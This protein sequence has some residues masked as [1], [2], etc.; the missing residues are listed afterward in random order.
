MLKKIEVSDELFIAFRD[1]VSA[2]TGLFFQN[3]KRQDLLRGVQHAA[4]TFGYK[5]AKTCMTQLLKVN[6][7]EKQIQTLASHLTV[8]ETHFY[9]H[10]EHLNY[11]VEKILGSGNFTKNMSL[12]IWSAGCCTGEE[13]YTL[14]IL[15]HENVPFINKYNISI[16][17][18]DINPVYLN[19][20]KEAVFSKNSF[21]ETPEYIQKKYFVRT[22]KGRYELDPKIKKM[23]K[24]RYLNLVSNTYPL[25]ISGT[26][27]IDVVF[28]RNV[29]I[30]FKP[31]VV[32]KICE[33]FKHSLR[34]NGYFFVSPA[35]TF[36]VS[37]KLFTRHNIE[38]A[39]VFQNSSI[40]DEKKK[41]V[42]SKLKKCT[43]KLKKSIELSK[44]LNK[45]RKSIE[46]QVT[47]IR[48]FLPSYAGQV[49]HCMSNKSEK[50][51]SV[52]NSEKEILLAAK[53]HYNKGNYGE[54]VKLL[55]ELIA[56]TLS[57]KIK[58]NAYIELARIYSNQGKM[59]RSLECCKKAIDLDKMN[60]AGYF[61]YASL[62]ME[63]GKIEE[64]IN[65][66][67]KTL[68]FD[69]SY[70]IAHFTLGNIYF[71]SNNR[72]QAEKYFK[73]A[74][75]LL[76]KTAPSD[77]IKGSEGLTAKSMKDLIK[78]CLGR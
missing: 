20:A 72:L 6:W 33:K 16:L 46:N 49:E 38:A 61:L 29:F 51:A 7:T 59:D 3:K 47:G 74:E 4:D 36:M 44:K 22:G 64:S 53:D 65:Y 9:R 34:K 39:L 19:K 28:C 8:G 67:K 56:K 68:Y 11:F 30:Y 50:S 31:D 69:N 57:V 77:V 43:T 23:V 27:S 75:H 14:A 35:E 25:Q 76:L 78:T 60:P 42:A 70:V 12:K 45:C 55:D 52:R 13:A 41:V 26:D 71:N 66:L 18:T 2:K 62:L 40:K 63:S 10:R 73:N 17:A 32:A 15:L 54:S 48:H 5:D 58:N 1:F 21:R 37:Q 24:F